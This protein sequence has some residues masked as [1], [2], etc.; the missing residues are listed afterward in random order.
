MGPAIRNRA[1]LDLQMKV[2][3]IA[4]YE[5]TSGMLRGSLPTC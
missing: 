3:L 2:L 4:G 5:S 1:E